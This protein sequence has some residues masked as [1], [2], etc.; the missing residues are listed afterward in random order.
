M[1]AYLAI[2]RCRFASLLQYRAAALAGISVQFFWGVLKVMILTAFYVSSTTLQPMALQDI[3]TFI[4]IGQGLFLLVPWNIDK[5]IEAQVRNGQVVYELV[6]P[7][8]L[9][10]LW[11]SR[12]LALRVVPVLLR[13]VVMYPIAYWLFGLALPVSWMAAC[14]FLIAICIAMLLASAI[15]TAVMLTLFWTI[16]GEGILRLLPHVTFLLSGMIVP[17]PLFPEFLQPVIVL[18]PLRG[19]ID[20]PSRL[21]TGMIPASQALPW[22]A[23][24]AF[25]LVVCIVLG[26]WM[27]K[28]ALRQFVVEGG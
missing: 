14:F 21:Y 11:F 18:Q 17:L 1:K 5:E 7:I 20:I 24:Q 23:F 26:R 3:I 10:W 28:K 25:W 12:S 19:I 15:T 9:Y 4:W 22:I 27:M 6:R 16:S 13:G 8:D 2:F